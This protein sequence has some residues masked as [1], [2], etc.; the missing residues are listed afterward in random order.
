MS[1]I[2]TMAF[3][4]QNTYA[5]STVAL[6]TSCPSLT[7]FNSAFAGSGIQEISLPT[8]VGSTISLGNA[9]TSCQ[10]LSSITIP[11]GW[12][13]TGTMTNAFNACRNL[14]TLN[15][16][17]NAQNSITDMT[18]AFA[19]CVNLENLTLT[20][21]QEFLREANGIS[22]SKIIKCFTKN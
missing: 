21:D 11:N 4:F 22:E 13:I 20:G 12:N 6:P 19:N 14:N 1:D 3:A 7:A 17:S 9:F 2:S 16:P 5:L 18:S 10:G 8:T 15:L